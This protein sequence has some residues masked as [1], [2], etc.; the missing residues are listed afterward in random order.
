[1]TPDDQTLQEQPRC[2]WCYKAIRSTTPANWAIDQS[3]RIVGILHS[4][5]A[6]NWRKE[7]D[8]PAYHTQPTI[9]TAAEAH[10]KAWATQWQLQNQRLPWLTVQAFVQMA[11]DRRGRR[12]LVNHTRIAQAKRGAQALNQEYRRKFQSYRSIFSLQEGSQ[13]PKARA[14]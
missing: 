8:L 1:M 14:I 13:P 9:H 4:R 12:T 2:L 10:R 7:Q 11:T 6:R 5:H 3:L